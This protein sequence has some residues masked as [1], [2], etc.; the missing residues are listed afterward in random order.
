MRPSH[1]S[2]GLKGLY[3]GF[4]FSYNLANIK[5]QIDYKGEEEHLFGFV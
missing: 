1:T 3:K 4:L 5:C 2:A